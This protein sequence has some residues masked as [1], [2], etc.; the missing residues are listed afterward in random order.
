MIFAG[1]D[2]GSITAKAALLEENKLLGT[3]V[4]PT[5]YNHLEAGKKVLSSSR[6]ETSWLTTV[7][8]HVH[9]FKMNMTQLSIPSITHRL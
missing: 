8:C 7:Y 1:I 2:I 6:D 5:G 3:L 4:I 9:L